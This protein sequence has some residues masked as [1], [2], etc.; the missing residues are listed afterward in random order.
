MGY[1]I[2]TRGQAALAPDEQMVSREQPEYG[3]IV[4]VK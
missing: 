4:I 2:L 3:M 1:R